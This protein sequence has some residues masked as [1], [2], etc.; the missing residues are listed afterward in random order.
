VVP[1][2]IIESMANTYF[3][4]SKYA[5][6][7]GARLPGFKQSR[8][9]LWVF[10]HTCEDFTKKRPKS[11]GFIYRKEN[12]LFVKCHHCGFGQSLG[13]FIAS[14]DS[15]MADEYR[16]E[17]YKER[18]NAGEITKKIAE[19]WKPQQTVDLFRKQESVTEGYD[20][21]LEGL[22]PLSKLP[23]THPAVKY[24]ASRKIPKEHY[25]RLFFA[26]KFFKYA[27]QFRDTFEK[28]EKAD[29]PRL[30]IPYFDGNDRVF[31]MTAR[32]FGE[33]TPRYL[34]VP[35]DKTKENIYG[36]WRIDPAKRIL[37]VEGQLDSL[38]LDNCLAIGGAD[39]S[40]AVLKQLQSN[41]IIVPDNDFVR[42]SQVANSVLRAIE[43]GYTV[44]LFPKN[45]KYKDINDAVKAG[46]TKKELHDMI[47]ENAKSGLQAKL[48]L[49]FRRKT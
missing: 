13:N 10:S 49:I 4:D 27:K 47:I 9:D 6:M 40:S 7:L 17:L 23:D 5:K 26:P 39:Y 34:F 19:E 12:K 41:L 22:F 29:Y 16:L 30:V 3:I 20:T 1:F 32:A 44:S 43:A 25:D 42:N 36:L 28:M 45:F 46:M 38:C 48:E 2:V 35:V 33:E 11:R 21:T 37:A 31:A 14:V 24:V 18:V 15:T 8:A